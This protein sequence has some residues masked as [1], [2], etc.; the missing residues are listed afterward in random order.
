MAPFGVDD[1][2][3]KPLSDWRLTKRVLAIAQHRPMEACHEKQSD[4]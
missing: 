2:Q 4:Q 3:A 1:F